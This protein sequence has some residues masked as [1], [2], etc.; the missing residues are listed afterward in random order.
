MKNLYYMIWAD[1]INSFKAH[2]PKKTNWKFTLFT[3][4]TWINA[5]NLFIIVLWMKYFKI[6]IVPHFDFNF[7]PGTLLD[8]FLTFLVEFALPLAILN[9]FLIF[10]KN[11]YQLI[12]KK[13]EDVKIRYAPIYSFTIAILALISA[14]LYGVFM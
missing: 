11:R 12:S 13:Y 2:N 14:I 10:Y 1:A 9:Y 5:L 8:G 4:I 3:Y 6:L 7:F